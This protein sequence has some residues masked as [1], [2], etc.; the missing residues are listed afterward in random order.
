MWRI[1]ARQMTAFSDIRVRAATASLSGQSG[2]QTPTGA[3]GLVENDTKP[4]LP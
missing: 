2:H 1:Y 4:D 3:A